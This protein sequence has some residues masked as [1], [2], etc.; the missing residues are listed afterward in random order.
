MVGSF[1]GGGFLGLLVKW[2]LKSVE[3]VAEDYAK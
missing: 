3:R 1:L 2:F